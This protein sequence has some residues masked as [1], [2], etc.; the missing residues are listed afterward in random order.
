MI[1]SS[2]RFYDTAYT[3][4]RKKHEERVAE[5]REGGGKDGQSVFDII[6]TENN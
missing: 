5:R 1:Y 2:V 6:G 4:H 3:F